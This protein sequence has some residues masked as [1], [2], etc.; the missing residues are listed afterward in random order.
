MQK[1]ERKET[2]RFELSTLHA[3]IR[4]V[5]L[6][7]HISY[8]LSFRKW[9]ASTTEIQ[10]AK[11]DKKTTYVRNQVSENKNDVN[12]AR[13]FFTNL[14]CTSEITGFDRKLII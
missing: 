1:T 14:T 9:S 8:D 11:K 6:I 2:S 4:L 10:K 13:N 5:A 12:T 7:L 3:W